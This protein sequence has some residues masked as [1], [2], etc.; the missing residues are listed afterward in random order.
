MPLAGHGLRPA[1][2]RQRAGRP[3]LKREPLG[4][5]TFVC[6]SAAL[7][8]RVLRPRL[9]RDPLDGDTAHM[10]GGEAATTFGWAWLAATIALALHG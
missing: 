5:I 2:L 6:G 10:I 1:A 9:K 4:G 3:Q 8:Q 7:R